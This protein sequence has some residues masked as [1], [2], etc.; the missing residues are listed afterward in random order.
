M[1]MYM[2]HLKLF[3]YPKAITVHLS[4]WQMR[5][6]QLNSNLLRTVTAEIGDALPDDLP[7]GLKIAAYTVDTK[8]SPSNYGVI[9]YLPYF[10]GTNKWFT[11]IACSTNNGGIYISSKTNEASWSEWVKI[12]TQ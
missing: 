11:A 12:Q 6:P 2:V 8:N 5:I 4:E 1:E 9:L 3:Q 7:N 10:D